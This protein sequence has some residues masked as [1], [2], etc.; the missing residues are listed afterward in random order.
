MSPPTLSRPLSCF[1]VFGLLFGLTGCSARPDRTDS[2]VARIVE[3]EDRR[4]AQ[5]TATAAIDFEPMELASAVA[6]IEAVALLYVSDGQRQEAEAESEPT[7]SVSVPGWH[8]HAPA[9]WAAQPWPLSMGGGWDETLDDAGTSKRRQSIGGLTVSSEEKD[10]GP[11][12]RARRKL[13]LGFNLLRLR[14][15]DRPVSFSASLKGLKGVQVKAT[16]KM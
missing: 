9:A 6:A 5:R 15:K 7:A 12:G 8:Y 16:I 14:I 13:R 11:D 3:R 1:T 2:V 4:Q 10:A